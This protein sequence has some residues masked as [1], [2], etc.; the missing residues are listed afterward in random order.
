MEGIHSR[1]FKNRRC[2]RSRSSKHKLGPSVQV[3]KKTGEAF[4]SISLKKQAFCH[5][6][7]R[8]CIHAEIVI[9]YKHRRI[10]VYTVKNGNRIPGFPWNLSFL[11]LEE[12][13]ADRG[14][15]CTLHILDFFF[16]QLGKVFRAM[17]GSRL[18]N[19]ISLLVCNPGNLAEDSMLGRTSNSWHPPPLQDQHIA[20][21]TIL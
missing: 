1:P 15:F 19:E 21:V 13:T 5:F 2:T 18:G 4:Q 12:L 17:K 14:K 7:D 9:Y 6:N 8:V 11:I 20:S 16:L 10:G 3:S